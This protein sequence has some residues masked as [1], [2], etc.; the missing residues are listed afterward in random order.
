MR[1]LTEVLEEHVSEPL[2]EVLEREERQRVQVRERLN[3][4]E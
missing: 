3:G 4:G 2:A 1:L